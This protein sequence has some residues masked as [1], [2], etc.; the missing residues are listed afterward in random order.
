MSLEALKYQDTVV[1]VDIVMIN[2][3]SIS[4]NF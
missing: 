3:I 2:T 4:D 1:I